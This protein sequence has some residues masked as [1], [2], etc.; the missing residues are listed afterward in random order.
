MPSNISCSFHSFHIVASEFLMA[1]CFIAVWSIGHLAT[2]FQKW[3]KRQIFYDYFLLRGHKTVK[4]QIF[5]KK[6][7]VEWYL[8]VWSSVIYKGLCFIQL[9]SLYSIHKLSSRGRYSGPVGSHEI[10][11]TNAH[12]LK[13]YL[14][15]SVDGYEE[16]GGNR[17]ES[18]GQD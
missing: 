17:G 4:N 15:N 2:S 6:S 16:E 1:A 9:M 3:V 5:G 10:A 11:C 14:L 7:Y 18:S 8:Y 13:P 12:G